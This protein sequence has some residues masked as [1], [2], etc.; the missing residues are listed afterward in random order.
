MEELDAVTA[1]CGRLG[2]MHPE[3]TLSFYSNPD[4]FLPITDEDPYAEPLRRLTDVLKANR[5]QPIRST[6][7][8]LQK[9]KMD[10]PEAEEYVNFFCD[11]METLR[12]QREESQQKML[13]YRNS[14]E[15]TIH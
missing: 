4:K 12:R 13:E 9:M 6:Q 3:N 1:I 11:K 14:A 2:E 7:K 8:A 15:E 10:L 5:L